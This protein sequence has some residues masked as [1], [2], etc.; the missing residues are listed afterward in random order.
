MKSKNTIEAYGLKGFNRTS[1]RREFKNHEALTAWAEK[2][3]AEVHGTRD[4][5]APRT[6]LVIEPGTS[7][8]R[9]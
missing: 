6:S 2:H 9:D 3:D 7:D 8:I 4:I 5:E 1:W